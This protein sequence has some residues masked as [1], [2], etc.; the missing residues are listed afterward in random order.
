MIIADYHISSDL[1]DLARTQVQADLEEASMM[2]IHGV[3]YIIIDQ[4]WSVS[5]AHPPH[6]F[7]PLFDAALNAKLNTFDA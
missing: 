6:A 5:G 3:P 1:I 4:R 7:L 2:D